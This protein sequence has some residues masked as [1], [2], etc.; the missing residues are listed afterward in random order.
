[1]FVDAG[2]SLRKII[3]IDKWGQNLN[4]VSVNTRNDFLESIKEL[5]TFNGRNITADWNNPGIT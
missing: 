5:R 4:G 1:M 2:T 3:D